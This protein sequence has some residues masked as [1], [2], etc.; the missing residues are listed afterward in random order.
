[1]N[2]NDAVRD[3][4]LLLDVEVRGVR[5]DR[6][7]VHASGGVYRN[8]SQNLARLRSRIEEDDE[9]RIYTNEYDSFYAAGRDVV[10]LAVVSR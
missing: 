6:V 10:I 4:I 2:A 7:R 1:M 3:E 9:I 8:N 5:H